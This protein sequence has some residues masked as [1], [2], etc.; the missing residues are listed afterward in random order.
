MH[1][2]KFTFHTGMVPK[3]TDHQIHAAKAEDADFIYEQCLELRKQKRGIYRYRPQKLVKHSI[4]DYGTPELKKLYYIVS[5]N[6]VKKG[7]FCLKNDPIHLELEE[8]A[9]MTPL[10]FDS[11]LSF[12]QEKAGDKN[13][14]LLS[15]PKDSSFIDYLES[16]SEQKKGNFEKNIGEYAWQ[17]LIPDYFSFFQSIKPVL[18]NNIAHSAFKDGEI[19]FDFNNYQELIE[20]HIHDSKIN[21]NRK[22]W[23]LT[24]DMNLPPQAVVKIIF[25]NF[26]QEELRP[27]IPDLIIKRKELKQLLKVLFPKH[28]VHFFGG[29]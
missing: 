11:V 7:Y 14:I 24:W 10:L 18:E 13:K 19:T 23:S 21:L 28:P 29:Y 27:V 9:E 3:Q 12:L 4:T 1:S 8:I 16:M 2:A 15:I 25:D 26:T 6:G 22:P 17:A 20:F 5:E